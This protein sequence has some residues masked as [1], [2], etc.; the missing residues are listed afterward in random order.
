MFISIFYCVAKF[1]FMSNRKLWFICQTK[2]NLAVLKMSKYSIK[3]FFNLHTL[4]NTEKHSL[5]FFFLI[6]IINFDLFVKQ[7]KM[8]YYFDSVGEVYHESFFN[9]YTLKNTEKHSLLLLFLVKIT[10]FDLSVEKKNC[11]TILTVL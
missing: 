1:N 9:L 11:P 7:N 6:K 4:E 2:I 3:S 5:F 8:S 10:N